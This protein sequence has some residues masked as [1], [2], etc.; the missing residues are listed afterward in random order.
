MSFEHPQALIPWRSPPNNRSW[1]RSYALG[2]NRDGRL[3]SLSRWQRIGTGALGLTFS[4]GGGASVFLTDNQAGSAALVVV[5]ALALVSAIV[6]RYPRTV[7]KD[8][9]SWG[10]D[11]YEEAAAEVLTTQISDEAIPIDERADLA[12]QIEAVAERIIETQRGLQQ[13]LRSGVRSVGGRLSG[14]GRLLAGA[15]RGALAEQQAAEVLRKRLGDQYKV[16]ALRDHR[17]DFLVT[18]P[19]TGRAFGVDIK[20]ISSPVRLG[21]MRNRLIHQPT[22]EIPVL[23][24]LVVSE[25]ILPSVRSAFDRFLEEVPVPLGIL[26]VNAPDTNPPILQLAAHL[27]AC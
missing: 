14:E 20:W 16:E 12:N 19:A 7:G 26:E 11:P 13:E 15:S 8:Q 5:G 17:Y 23:T 21:A 3:A 4:G 1:S 2:V 27:L 10:E 9:V 25:D 18:D 22:P 6:G 24:L